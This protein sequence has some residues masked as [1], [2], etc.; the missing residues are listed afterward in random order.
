MLS[1]GGV[2]QVSQKEFAV[3]VNWDIIWTGSK[4]KMYCLALLIL[5]CTLF[6]VDGSL[7]SQ[8]VLMVFGAV[9]SNFAA[10]S[11]IDAVGFTVNGIAA[12]SWAERLETFIAYIDGGTLPPESFITTLQSI[13]IEGFSL[14][15]KFLLGTVGALIFLLISMNLRN[16]LTR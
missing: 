16:F 2:L 8:A 15:T 6:T 7:R 12:G 10:R 11:I 4:I 1:I 14:S 9:C 3:F 5:A 13:G